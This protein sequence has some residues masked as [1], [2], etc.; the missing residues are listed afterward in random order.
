[1]KGDDCS[2]HIARCPYVIYQLLDLM[3]SAFKKTWIW[4]GWNIQ[5]WQLCV[6]TQNIL[7]S[8]GQGLSKH[9]LN[10]GSSNLGG[11]WRKVGPIFYEADYEKE[12]QEA[13][14]LGFEILLGNTE[15]SPKLGSRAGGDSSPPQFWGARFEIRL[16][17]TERNFAPWDYPANW[18]LIIGRR[19]N[20]KGR[21]PNRG[22][23]PKQVWPSSFLPGKRKNGERVGRE[24]P[25]EKKGVNHHLANPLILFGWETRIWTLIHGV[26]VRCPTIERSPSKEQLNHPPL[27]HIASVP[28]S[29]RSGL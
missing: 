1:M 26:R 28:V 15:T 3:V 11:H 16:G 4:T 8:K 27:S 6:N 20:V 18:P 2:V 12:L 24:S 10:P 5:T 22:G 19:G 13:R 21:P 25:A 9:Q 23:R 14:P 29:G 17:F 7:T